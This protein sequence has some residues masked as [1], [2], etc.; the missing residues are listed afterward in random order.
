MYGAIQVDAVTPGVEIT[1]LVN[2][3]AKHGPGTFFN[4]G[5]NAVLRYLKNAGSIQVTNEPLPF[6]ANGVKLFDTFASVSAAISILIAFSFIPA[7]VA[8]FIVKERE[9]SAKHQQIISGAS[10]LAYWLSSYIWDMLMFMVPWTCSL[11]CLYGFQISSYQGENLFATAVLFLCYGHGMIP[12]T[13][14]VCF[15]FDSHSTAQNMLLLLNFTS[16]LILMIASF[17][18]SSIDST[19]D[20]NAT[21]VYLYRLFPGFCLGNGLLDLTVQHTVDEFMGQ[22]NISPF[23][24]DVLGANLAYLVAQGFMW[25]ALTLIIDYSLNYPLVRQRFA[26]LFKTSEESDRVETLVVQDEDVKLEQMRIDSDLLN[27]ADDMLV[28]RHLRKVYGSKVAVN[29]LTF[30]VAK[31]ACFGFLGVNGAG[32]TSTIKILTGDFL[33]TE[34]T[35]S[36]ADKDIIRNQSEIRRN[37]GYCP[38][39]DALLEHLTVQEHLELF[40]RLKFIPE[41]DLTNVVSRSIEEM[42]LVDFRDKTASTLSGGNKR[43]LSVAIAL[44]GSPPLVFLDEPSTGMDVMNRR[45]MWQIISQ[46]SSKGV[47]VF[48]TSHSM[49]ECEA[50]CSRIGIMVGGGL[51]CLGTIQHLKSRFGQ[52]LIVDIKLTPK[53]KVVPELSRTL[54]KDQVF[55]VCTLLGIPSRW[56]QVSLTDP[57]GWVIASALEK[58]G[59]IATER[60]LGWWVS[61]TLHDALETYILSNFPGSLCLEKRAINCKW[62]I[63]ESDKSLAQVF[64]IFESNKVELSIA[65]YS[66]CQTT[67]EQI[68]V[69]FAS[70]EDTARVGG[71]LNV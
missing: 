58:T 50:L 12:F 38:Q 27:Q 1:F 60:F 25:F 41:A 35:A 22:Q 62:R 70:R 11:L 59:E 65:E 10:I 57:T 67:L 69:R 49:D 63:S 54:T 21:M 55:N 17:V 9:N 30:G 20:I 24:W 3:T 53:P 34:G 23:A 39:F 4:V 6:T 29:D 48:L 15:L 26:R 28:L 5:S 32:K 40:G 46:L 36:L 47:T 13:Y 52:G 43:K 71:I 37:I 19:K 56:E 33:P 64:E 44:M 18:M 68:F 45:F 61:E 14:C 42:N 31:G 66:V 16:G 7:A 2:S 51:S 8:I